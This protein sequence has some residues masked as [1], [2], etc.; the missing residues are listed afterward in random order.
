[1]TRWRPYPR[2]ELSVSSQ[3]SVDR[4]G[5][6]RSAMASLEPDEKLA[7]L[8]QHHAVNPHAQT[9][10]DPL[11]TGDHAFFDPRDLVQVKYEMLRRVREGQS[12]TQAASAFGFSRVALYQTKAALEKGV[13][14]D[15]YP[16]GLAHGE[17][18]SSPRKSSASLIRSRRQILRL[19][20]GS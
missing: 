18:T 15:F 16:D 4:F 9:V 13:S 2:M 6:E 5:P 20:S 7:A 10:T 14:W 19:A 17:R 11:F 3:G 8:R 1:L 12:V